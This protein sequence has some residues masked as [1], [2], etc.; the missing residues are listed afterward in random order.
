MILA[1]DTGNTRTKWAIFARDGKLQTAGIC[2][3]ADLD[4]FEI[5]VAWQSCSHAIAANVAGEGIAKKLDALLVKARLPF[6]W[7]QAKAMSCG[8]KNGY[9]LPQQLGVDRWAS[10]VAA[11]KRYANQP[12]CL[13]V[14][15]G[16]ALTVDSLYQDAFLGGLIVPGLNMMQNALV[17]HTDAV[18][19]MY[20]QRQDLP[21]NTADAS[22][23]GV[24]MAMVGAIVMQADQLESRC[25]DV[26]SIVMTGGDAEL[27]LPI[28]TPIF[29]V[30]PVF[31][32][33]L[34]LE[35]LYLMG[36]ETA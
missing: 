33:S 12:A 13:V 1:V 30:K 19:S 7:A 21:L 8:L 28:L 11:Y 20:G 29:G 25:Q 9:E 10:M 16:T 3:N 15:V 27:L 6:A 32:E 18:N 26:P 4:G 31:V 17:Q 34:V 35:G 5:P 23:S 14:N 36:S 22:Y 2:L 24:I